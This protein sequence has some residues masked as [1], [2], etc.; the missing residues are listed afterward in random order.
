MATRRVSRR[1]ERLGGGVAE[2]LNKATREMAR[3]QALVAKEEAR[4]E[5]RQALADRLAAVPK[6]AS[7]PFGEVVL[8]TEEDGTYVR[9]R[10]DEGYPELEGGYG[11]WEDEPRPGQVSATVF[12]GT[13]APQLTLRLILGGYPIQ[14]A[15][16]DCD[17]DIRTL[18]ALGRQPVDGP[19]GERPP[20][21]RLRG[22]VPHRRR[23]WFVED[24]E[25]GEIDVAGGKRV[26]A[27]VTVTLRMF[28]PVT[29][30]RLN[31]PRVRKSARRTRWYTLKRGDTFEKIA[32]RELRARGDREIG[33]AIKSIRSLNPRLRDGK[34]GIRAAGPKIKLPAGRRK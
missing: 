1:G 33:A 23:E 14:P 19:R 12:R 29:L 10:L 18:D 34:K 21:L 31:D 16:S 6:G 15:W 5:Q 7:L 25:W 32:T 9:A 11:G 26:R 8:Y 30:L 17:R 20:L 3:L 13:Q 2:A 24:I 4:A 27:F 22:K 28:V